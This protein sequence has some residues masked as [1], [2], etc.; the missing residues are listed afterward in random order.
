MRI[1]PASLVDMAELGRAQT[2]VHWD[3]LREMWRNGETWAMWQGEDL[4]GLAGVYP[5]SDN[6]VEAWF[7]LTPAVGDY[8]TDLFRAMRLTLQTRRYPEIVV[9]CSTR[10]GKVMARRM[11][12][13]FVENCELGEIWSWKL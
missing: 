5:I 9:V 7:N 10:A 2:R 8:L 3:I 4:V 13:S 1:E 6:V 12:F 11:G